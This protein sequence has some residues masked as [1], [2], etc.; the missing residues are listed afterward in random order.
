MGT[1]AD[2]IIRIAT[3]G[4]KLAQAQMASLGKSSQ[5]AGG[6]LATFAKVGSVAVVGAML[7]VAKGVFE[8]VQAFAEFD[9]KM[10]QSL[11]IMQ[12]TTAQQEQMARVAREVATVTAI[13]ATDS[14]EAYFFLA[15]A[16]LI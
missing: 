8:S 6:K 14:A 13:S 3:Q 7:G 2:L 9:S 15:S 11:A 12:T 10:T 5:L 16:G 1:G 4:A